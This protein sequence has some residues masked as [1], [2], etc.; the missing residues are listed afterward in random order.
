MTPDTTGIDE[1]PP[2]ERKYHKQRSEKE[3]AAPIRN[4][5]RII[6]R[7]I[8]AAFFAARFIL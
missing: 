8:W 1:Q 7:V 5:F 4:L 2:E 3:L 6:W